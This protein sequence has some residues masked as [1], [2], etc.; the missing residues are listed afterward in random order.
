M[1]ALTLSRLRRAAARL[2]GDLPTAGPDFFI[3]GATR[4]GTTYL[5]HALRAHPDIFLPETKELQYFNRD[6][7][8]SRDLKGYR[9]RFWGYGGER[10]VGEA[11]PLYMTA[12]AVYDRG[13]TLRIGGPGDAVERIARHFPDTRLVVSLRDPATRIL[14]IYE[15]NLRQGKLDTPLQSLIEQE[16]DGSASP[17]N[18]LYLNDYRTHLENVLRQFPRERVMILI[19]EEWRAEPEAAI[20]RLQRFLGVEPMFRE[21]SAPEAANRRARYGELD[22]ERIEQL[23]AVAEQTMAR[24]LARLA[25]SRTWIEELLGRGL[26]WQ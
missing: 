18:L 5:Y 11:T 14:S 1:T 9:E 4:A 8:Y 2:K 10:A 17:L 7:R 26:P 23:S 25:P 24:A 12:H 22:A 20:E 21:P 13:G 15:K 16:L 19:F 6:R 3:I